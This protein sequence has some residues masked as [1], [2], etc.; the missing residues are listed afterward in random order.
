[1]RIYWSCVAIASIVLTVL[2]GLTFYIETADHP[3]PPE[4]IPLVHE[5]VVNIDRICSGAIIQEGLI[6]TAAHCVQDRGRIGVTFYDFQFGDFE[7]IYI[8]ELGGPEDYALLRGNTRGLKAL[9]LTNAEPNFLAGIMHYGYSG[10]IHQWLTAGLYLGYFCNPRQCETYLSVR[11][12][13]GDS[14][15][16]VVNLNNEVIGIVY[17]SYWPINVGLSMMVPAEIIIDKIKELGL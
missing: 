5:S 16:V 4:K 7:L 1:M 12:I 14:G 9:P 13:P 8:G 11:T 3:F 15:G 6:V 10:S 2:I 17:S